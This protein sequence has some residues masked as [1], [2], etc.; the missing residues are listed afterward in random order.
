MNERKLKE[1]L[2]GGLNGLSC[3]QNRAL[4]IVQ[5]NPDPLA[6]QCLK[7]EKSHMKSQRGYYLV[8]A[9]IL[10]LWLVGLYFNERYWNWI[11]VVLIFAIEQ[12]RIHYGYRQ[13]RVLFIFRTLIS[14]YSAEEVKKAA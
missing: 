3:E 8:E 7:L 14:M 12:E 5:E 13:K 4:A 6:E 11:V 9:V 10:L 1:F 2:R